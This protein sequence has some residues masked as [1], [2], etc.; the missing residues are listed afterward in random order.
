MV[1]GVF[2]GEGALA[3][4]V[5]PGVSEDVVVE[6]APKRV[7]PPM[8]ELLDGFAAGVATAAVA[9][10]AELIPSVDDKEKDVFLL[11]VASVDEE[12]S[13][14][15]LAVNPPKSDDPPPPV[16]VAAK[17][18]APKLNPPPPDPPA[19]D[20]EASVVV[21]GAAT[22]APPKLKPVDV[23]G[24]ADDDV[25][26]AAEPPKLNPPPPPAV[27]PL[28]APPKENPPPL[29]LEE[30]AAGV[31]AAPDD[32]VV[33]VVPK[34]KAMMLMSMSMSNVGLPLAAPF[35]GWIAVGCVDSSLRTSTLQS[36]GGR[37]VR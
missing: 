17:A 15:A 5:I 34:L 37:I 21:V 7:V 30:E 4:G 28:A 26:A 14:A 2:T 11:D 22:V 1:L 31:G 9:D 33:V 29:L 25:D 12:V 24:A 36:F 23:D 18:G 6:L 8:E 35:V 10:A 13:L 20:F 32:G 3:A 19:V 16:F 27:E